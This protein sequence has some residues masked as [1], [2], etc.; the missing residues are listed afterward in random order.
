MDVQ[1]ECSGLSH[2]FW[3]FISTHLKWKEMASSDIVCVYVCACMCLCMCVYVHVFVYVCV[4]TCVCVCV[5]DLYI[6][7]SMYQMLPHHLC[8]TSRKG[9]I[10]QKAA[11]QHLTHNTIHV[12]SSAAASWP[13]AVSHTL[14]VEISRLSYMY[15]SL[16]FFLLPGTK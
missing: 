16:M 7:S 15:F 4:C 2:K 14:L 6:R 8:A 3:K 13:Q 12:V 1:S 11:F 5:C 10:S 9:L